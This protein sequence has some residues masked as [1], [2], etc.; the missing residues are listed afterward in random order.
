MHRRPSVPARLLAPALALT[1]SVA[2]AACSGGSEETPDADLEPN[3]ATPSDSGDAAPLPEEEADP[4][5]I[6]TYRVC[7]PVGALG[8]DVLL[9][10]E[11][12]EPSED[13]TIDAVDAVGADGFTLV[14]SWISASERDPGGFFDTMP[15]S[16]EGDQPGYAWAERQPAVGAELTGGQGYH[17]FVHLRRADDAAIDGIQL[18]YT[19]GGESFTA[20]TTNRYVAGQGC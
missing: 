17:L 10:E 15:P 19:S 8:E 7:L 16:G 5:E 9:R 12:L 18:S 13:L 1:A 4:L 2:L 6:E 3:L 20:A 14:E 11:Y